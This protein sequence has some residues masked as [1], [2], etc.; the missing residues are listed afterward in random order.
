MRGPIFPPRAC[1]IHRVPRCRNQ[2]DY[3][4]ELWRPSGKIDLVDIC[5]NCLAEIRGEDPMRIIEVVEQD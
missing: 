5:E 1:E 3:M 4:V 2:K